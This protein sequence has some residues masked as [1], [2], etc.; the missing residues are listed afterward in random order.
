ME[1]CGKN[2]GCPCSSA[3]MC[4]HW[5]IPK[6]SLYKCFAA[7]IINHQFGYEIWDSTCFYFLKLFFPVTFNFVTKLRSSKNEQFRS[8]D[9]LI[10]G[11]HDIC[12]ERR[13]FRFQ[14]S[15]LP[16]NKL[17]SLATNID[18]MTL[19]PILH[20]YGYRFTNCTNQNCAN[21][22]EASKEMVHNVTDK[23]FLG[24]QIKGKYMYELTPQ[25]KPKVIECM[26]KNNCSS[27]VIVNMVNSTQ[28]KNF[29]NCANKHCSDDL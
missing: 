19:S 24:C 4:L 21:E 27:Q 15:F 17:K 26:K 3:K 13:K 14:V 16:Q 22:T 8:T 28:F 11:N 1:V 7:R 29:L 2:D 9:N 25:E 10:S 12:R 23:C 20:R 5:K 6:E 18:L